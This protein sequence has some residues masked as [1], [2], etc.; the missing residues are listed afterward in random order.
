MTVGE[1]GWR[2]ESHPGFADEPR[3]RAHRCAGRWPPVGDDDVDLMECERSEKR[4]RLPLAANDAHGSVHREDRPQ[5]LIGDQLRNDVDDSDGQ[6]QRAPCRP[7]ADGVE[8]LS[9][10]REDVVR[11]SV[12]D[13]TDLGEH[14]RPPLTPEEMLPEHVLQRADLR[15]DGRLREPQ[16]IG[17]AA[18]A[19]LAGG[20]PEVEEVVIVQP[21]HGSSKP[22]INV[23]FISLLNATPDAMARLRR[24]RH[25]NGDSR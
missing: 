7:V 10:E 22:M 13:A 16:L 18:H 24:N 14:E 3:E 5:Q 12:D 1:P 20:E 8:Q 2:E 15:A 6:A 17:G 21:F 9:A 4:V 19:A 25:E 23:Q 11:I